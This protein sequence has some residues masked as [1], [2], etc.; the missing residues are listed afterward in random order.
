MPFPLPKKRKKHTHKHEDRP[1]MID[2]T[3][4]H[5]FHICRK[6]GNH[7]CIPLASDCCKFWKIWTTKMRFWSMMAWLK[8]TLGG[9]HQPVNMQQKCALRKRSNYGF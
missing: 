2:Y 3:P 5:N 8:H 1:Q 7:Y 6:T 4:S 9:R